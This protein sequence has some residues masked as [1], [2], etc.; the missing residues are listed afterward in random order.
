MA[1]DPLSTIGRNL[2]IV[3]NKLLFSRE[4]MGEKS[5]IPP[6]SL[7]RI[8]KNDKYANA[9]DREKYI[10]FLGLNKDILSNEDFDYTWQELVRT[11]E[12][13]QAN[14][15]NIC[16]IPEK[17][18]SAL[19][20]I[21]Y[22]ALPANLLLK[23]ITAKQLAEDINS[24]FKYSFENN[25]VQNALNNLSEDGTL[26][27]LQASP[28]KY[29]RPIQN[30]PKHIDPLYELTQNLFQIAEDNDI[31]LV[32]ITLRK[33]AKILMILAQDQKPRSEIFEELK[34]SNETN[35]SRRTIQVLEKLGLIFKTE[36]SLRSSK[37]MY[38]LTQ[39]GQELLK[40]VGVEMSS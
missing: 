3:R 36:S 21:K 19:K 34:M 26:E 32:N 40:K 16:K 5:G 8:E 37:Q 18:L 10:D 28:I 24:H 27:K 25:I 12:K 39:K 33:N 17:R 2:E 29:H 22:R 38:R 31:H 9:D 20:V 1:N 13:R 14:N 30:F 15:L 23:P 6:R 35:N 11:L 4:L 7:E